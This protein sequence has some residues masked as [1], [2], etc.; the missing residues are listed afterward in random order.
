M[1]CLN[2]LPK[3]MADILAEMLDLQ[4]LRNKGMVMLCFANVI[5]MLGFYAPIV[6]TANRAKLMGID[7]TKA[8]F[9]LSI[10]GKWI[11]VENYLWLS[12]ARDKIGKSL[13]D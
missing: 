12:Y 6:F 4:V 7:P 9:L 3:P 13:I 11:R 10:M 5:G 1:A 8:A 2:R